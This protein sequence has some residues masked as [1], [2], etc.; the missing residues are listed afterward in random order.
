MFRALLYG[1]VKYSCL[2][3]L[4]L[5]N[6]LSIEAVDEVPRRGAFIVAANH[7]SNLDPVVIGAACP[8]RLRFMAK[9]ELFRIPLLGPLIRALGAVPV[10]RSDRQGAAAV[11]RLTLARLEASESVIL[12]PEG[13]RSRDGRLKGLEGGVALLAVKTGLPVI[14]A[15]ISGSYEA[16]PGGAPFPRPVKI[17]LRFGSPLRA[18]ELLPEGSEKERRQAL[19]RRLERELLSLQSSMAGGADD[20]P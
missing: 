10:P 18:A 8:R 5:Y 20:H 16:L 11:L 15:F 7:C 6:R 13:T 3:W 9:E 17:R 2:L 14:P 19:L 1:C 4:R 12:F